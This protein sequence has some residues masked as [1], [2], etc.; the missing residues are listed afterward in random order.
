PGTAG[1]TYLFV[2][3]SFLAGGAER[4]LLEFLPRLAASGV[5][6]VVVCL[7]QGL[8]GFE[9]ELFAQGW[10]VRVLTGRGRMG[11]IRALRRLM[12]EIRPAL[13]YTALFDADLAGRLASIGLDIPV[14]TN[15]VNTAYDPARAADPNVDARKLALVRMI[16]GFTA[17]HFTNHFHA[18]SEAVKQSTVETMGVPADRIT[19]VLRGR[20]PDRLGTPSPGRTAAAR[21]A[22]G[23]SAAHQV[24]VAVGRQEYQK[25]HRHLV[26]A[27]GLMAGSHPDAVLTIAGR[28]GNATAALEAQIERL[29]LG[30]RVRLLGHRGDVAEV[31]AAA[32]VFAFPSLY[33]GLGGALIEAMALGLPIVASDLAALREVV[34]PGENADLVPPADPAALAQALSALLNDEP[35]RGEYGARSREL[36][37]QGFNGAAAAEALVTL[38]ARIAH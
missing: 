4:S 24:V 26:D 16:D 1:T 22:L 7:R 27:V 33:E 14:V 12:R 19:V 34:H 2:I 38:L 11:V 6:P 20:D 30:G 3:N 13:V 32:D 10:D 21:T 29:G 18:I 5:R 17:R 8:V 31:L 15:L 35:R 23:L 28:K 25:G 37:D 36:F 9:D